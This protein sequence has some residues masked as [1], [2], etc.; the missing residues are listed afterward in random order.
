ML[1][2]PNSPAGPELFQALAEPRRRQLLEA[3]VSGVQEVGE[4]GRRCDMPRALVAHHL[5][6]LGRAG[7]VQFQRRHAFVRPECLETLRRYFDRAL[8]AAAISTLRR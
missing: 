8:T 6:V 1:A 4:L 5:G 2:E 3:L 7:L